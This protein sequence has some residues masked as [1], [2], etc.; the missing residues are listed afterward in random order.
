MCLVQL[1]RTQHMSMR[2]LKRVPR[3]VPWRIVLDVRARLQPYGVRTRHVAAAT[4]SMETGRLRT[5]A[6]AQ[7]LDILALQQRIQLERGDGP[8]L[9][10]GPSGRVV[11]CVDSTAM[12]KCTMTRCDVALVP[13][14]GITTVRKPHSWS[15]WWSMDG[16]DDRCSL[17]AT[18]SQALLTEQVTTV[19]DSF[20][21]AMKRGGYCTVRCCLSGDGKLMGA[22]RQSA[23]YMEG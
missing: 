12:W 10:E 18:D 19:H 7:L 15:T 9:F 11:V 5:A 17:Q 4:G 14:S 20:V 21:L 1:M 8:L 16:G 6:W 2:A 23:A 22:C 3:T 13:D